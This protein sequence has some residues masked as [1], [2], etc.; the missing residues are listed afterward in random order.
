MG[1]PSWAPR[2]GRPHR[3]HGQGVRDCAPALGQLLYGG[4]PTAQVQ[5]LQVTLGSD[6]E[7]IGFLGCSQLLFY[8][9][10]TESTYY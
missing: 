2:S 4:D 5:E 9:E 7:A 10:T 1:C 3:Q 6:G 8:S